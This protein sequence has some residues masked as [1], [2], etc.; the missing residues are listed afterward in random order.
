[1]LAADV[2]EVTTEPIALGLLIGLLGFVAFLPF[3]IRDSRRP[4]PRP[5]R[6][7]TV[8]REPR[9]VRSRP[10]RPGTVGPDPTQTRPLRTGTVRNLPVHLPVRTRAGRQPV[11]PNAAEH[12]VVATRVPGHRVAIAAVTFFLMSTWANWAARARSSSRR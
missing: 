7:P 2:L 10:V 3:V 11:V 1:M 5:V 9:P 12:R 4:L 8:V 6:K